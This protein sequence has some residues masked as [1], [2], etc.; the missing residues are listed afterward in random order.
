VA[1][2]DGTAPATGT[3]RVL[4]SGVKPPDPGEFIGTNALSE[5]LVALQNGTDLVLIDAP[6]LLHVGDAM[7][8]SGKIDAM[9]VVTRLNVVRRPMLRE[10]R[11]L[12][13]AS[14]ATKLGFVLTGAEREE[15]GYGYGGYGRYY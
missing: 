6:P 11:R 3:L 10:L 9:I 7:T 1:S 12:L 4:P 2:R 15:G 14:P 5:V 8:L 13:A